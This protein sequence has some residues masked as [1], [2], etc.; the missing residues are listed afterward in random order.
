[1]TDIGPELQG[2]IE[3]SFTSRF[4]QDKI[5]ARLHW[6]IYESGY[7]AAE[8]WEAAEQ[9]AARTGE[10]LAE[11]LKRNIS[12]DDL[13][14]G[15]LY[16]NIAERIIGDLVPAC[17]NRVAEVAKYTQEAV[18]KAAGIS[19]KAVSP[20][21]K[22]DR[23]E[24]LIYKVS[25]AEN[26]E[27]VAWALDEPV[28]NIIQSAVDDTIRENVEFHARAGLSPKVTRVATGG[29]CKWCASLAGKYDYPVPRDVY[30]R[31][32]RCRCIVFYDPGDGR[33][34]DVWSKRWADPDEENKIE[35][36]KAV[37]LG[38]TDGPQN[39]LPEYMRNATPKRGEIKFGE[40]Y[41]K[42]SHAA[43]IETATWLHDY[44]G[45]EITLLP[46]AKTNG[47]MMPDYIWRDKNW[48]LKCITSA[49]AA[50]SAVRKALKQIRDNPGGIILNCEDNDININKALSI[51]QGRF[52]RSGT[53]DV[54]IL[55][56]AN[57]ELIRALRY[58]K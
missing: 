11:A 5:L 20:Q 28:V 13:P 34:Q 7:S 10:L 14:D 29:C 3:S 55:I 1:M 48:E 52:E 22:S 33:K 54:D 42:A 45:G 23:I 26:Y 51:I 39:V 27:D 38:T 56:L 44:L 24:K 58:K 30:R 47:I 50:D 4:N 12:A 19:M 8:R 35:L 36:R 57:G 21:I 43:E 17:Y 53:Y 41:D 49:K 15:R 40:G 16:Y 6:A 25:N 32:E 18:N 2:K 31:H 46:E 9:Y 37:G